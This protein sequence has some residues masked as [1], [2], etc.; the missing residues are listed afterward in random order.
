MTW[1]SLNF[2]LIT[3]AGVLALTGLAGLLPAAPVLAQP[4]STV[5]SQLLDGQKLDN[6]Q[7]GKSLT[8]FLVDSCE[9]ADGCPLIRVWK[10]LLTLV[11]LASALFLITVGFATIFH[12]QV[13]SYHLKKILTPL[14]LGIILANFSLLFSRLVI[15]FSQT[16]SNLFYQAAGGSGDQGAFIDN[17]AKTIIQADP[18]GSAAQGDYGRSI[19]W[20]VALA[21]IVGLGTLIGLGWI[22]L[23]LAVLIGV[24]VS[25]VPG[26]LILILAFLLYA[27]TYI[28]LFLSSI[29]PLAFMTM[30]IPATQGVFKRWWQ[31]MILWSFMAPA[32]F[33]LL[34]LA[35][36]FG[37]VITGG[38]APNFGSYILSL[39][40][41]YLAVQVPFRMGGAVMSA[42]STIGKKSG[43]FGAVKGFNALSGKMERH[44]WSRRFSPRAVYGGLKDRFEEEKVY[45]LSQAKGMVG[46]YLAR[47]RPLEGST[48]WSPW[49]GIQ[50]FRNES[51]NANFGQRL[52]SAWAASRPRGSVPTNQEAL[53]SQQAR[54]AMS[55][56][57]PENYYNQF[58]TK[59]NESDG[60]LK[61]A[62]FL[63]HY[64]GHYGE[65]NISRVMAQD[66]TDKFQGKIFKKWAIDDQGR[67]VR[68]NVEIQDLVNSA[69][70]TGNKEYVR[71]TRGRFSDQSASQ[72]PT[73]E[74]LELLQQ[75]Q[76]SQSASPAGSNNAQLNLLREILQVLQ[77]QQVSDAVQSAGAALGHTNDPATAFRAVGN[78][79]NVTMQDL[80][81]AVQQLN[82]VEAADSTS[83][84]RRAQD[85]ARANLQ[86]IR[87][88][89]N[90]V[91]TAVGQ[92]QI[93]QDLS[94]ETR[95]QIL[96][97]MTSVQS[98][99][100]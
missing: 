61:G 87:N 99:Q 53:Y 86:A 33:F 25:L 32:V 56:L 13:D 89:I 92:T 63:Q 34:W 23:S 85:N 49:R 80:N 40:M 28:L 82:L 98:Q 75:A 30:V 62:A 46:S 73:Q 38:G 100:S 42:W 94:S 88:A 84:V 51:S 20:I 81:Q 6:I 12:I 57:T 22:G 45:N 7:T 97:A 52:K 48:V 15:D 39:A 35:I 78:L 76:A 71:A 4:N 10:S 95:Q 58:K 77:H 8:G 37:G 69:Q 17:L 16:F 50:A 9:D 55:E 65:D 59:I 5:V 54:Q 3:L 93:I 26:S 66:L 68:N 29:A 44:D 14:I 19:N 60:H 27:R 67:L 70:K 11:N 1:F 64:I 83:V 41:L 74:F 91:S 21:G 79:S 2:K 31:Q 47:T 18:V 24:V 43:T 90:S 72:N 96:Q 36:E